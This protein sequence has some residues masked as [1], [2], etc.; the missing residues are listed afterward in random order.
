MQIIF[1]IAV[2]IVLLA[3]IIYKIN[4]RF[5][6]KELIIFFS[7]IVI[8][9]ILGVY[10]LDKKENVVPQLF[11]EKYEKE[12]NAKIDK[13]SFERLNNKT[14]SS[15]TNFIYNFDFIVLKNNDE[16]VCSIKNVKIKKIEDEYVF[17]NYEN[18]EQECSKK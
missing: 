18:L 9:I 1:F 8:S 16:Y 4:N 5:Q 12:N 3:V 13:L 17:E 10:F 7:I 14:V 2:F 15:S 6:T 11:K